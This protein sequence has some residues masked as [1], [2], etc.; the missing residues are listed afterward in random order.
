MIAIAAQIITEM[1]MTTQNPQGWLSKGTPVFMPQKEPIMLG[2][3]TM[4][5][6]EVKTFIATFKLLEMIEA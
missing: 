5:V 3:A 2:T 4:R 6:R 1:P